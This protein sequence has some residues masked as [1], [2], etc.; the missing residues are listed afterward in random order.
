MF[1]T[2]VALREAQAARKVDASDVV[3][4]SLSKRSAEK[5]S[6]NELLQLTAGESLEADRSLVTARGT[7]KVRYHETYKGVPVYDTLVTADDVDEYDV[8]GQLV[9]SIAND[10]SDVTPKISRSEAVELA[11]AAEGDGGDAVYENERARLFVYVDKSDTA[12]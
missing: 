3:R 12:R 11:K 7:K 9:Q 5:R 1:P 8:A 10:L 4:R 6:L 2:G